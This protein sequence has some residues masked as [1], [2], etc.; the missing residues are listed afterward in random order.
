MMLYNYTFSVIIGVVVYLVVGV[1]VMK[2]KYSAAGTDLIPN[3]AFW[4]GFPLLLKVLHSQCS[5]NG[6]DFSALFCSYRMVF[7][8]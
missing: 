5:H 6:R 3:N 4:A 7:Y 2:F 8:L 1:I